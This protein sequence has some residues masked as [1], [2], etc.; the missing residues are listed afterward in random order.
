MPRKKTGFL[1]LGIIFTA[2]C[3]VIL[4]PGY[5]RLRKIKKEI[6]VMRKN[7]NLLE[8]ENEKLRVEIDKLEHDPFAIEK[9]AREKLGMIREGEIK[10]KFVSP[11]TSTIENTKKK[12]IKK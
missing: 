12:R 3:F 9:K 10:F 4:A 11:E 8:T 6:A 7:I 2:V 5:L 1:K